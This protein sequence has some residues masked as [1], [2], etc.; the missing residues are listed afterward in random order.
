MLTTPCTMQ[1]CTSSEKGKACRRTASGV[2]FTSM[3]IASTAQ[4]RLFYARSSRQKDTC[5]L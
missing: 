3:S 2:D 5:G 4:R 1:G